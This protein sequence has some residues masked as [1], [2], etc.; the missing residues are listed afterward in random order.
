MSIEQADTNK[1]TY[2]AYA[3]SATALKEANKTVDIDKLDDTMQDLQE[4]MQVNTEIEEVMKSPLTARFGI[5]ET[6]L[7]TEL[8]ELMTSD[9]TKDIKRELL[10]DSMDMSDVLKNLPEVPEAT[11]KEKQPAMC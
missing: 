11:P 6:E 1:L 9:A 8:A 4:M 7:N 10:E 2:D 5:D 3:K